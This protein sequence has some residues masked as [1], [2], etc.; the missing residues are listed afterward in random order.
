MTRSWAS[1]HCWATDEYVCWIIWRLATSALCSIS[2]A[3]SCKTSSFLWSTY[4]LQHK[5]GNERVN[6]LINNQRTCRVS[7]FKSK[8]AIKALR[9]GTLVAIS[10]CHWSFDA[11]SCFISSKSLAYSVAARRSFSSWS[12]RS[13]DDARHFFTDSDKLLTSFA[14]ISCWEVST[15]CQIASAVVRRFSNRT[16]ADELSLK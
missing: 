10:S 16:W 5:L 15:D 6:A 7:I 9:A 4:R 3:F 2:L 12:W 1:R 11:T 14:R 8:L 13:M